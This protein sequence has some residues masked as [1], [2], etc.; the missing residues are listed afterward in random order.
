MGIDARRFKQA[1][2]VSAEDRAVGAGLGSGFSNFMTGTLASPFL[3][4]K[5]RRFSAK[6]FRVRPMQHLKRI[7]GRE[8][9][10]SGVTLAGVSVLGGALK[11]KVQAA[12]EARSKKASAAGSM[13]HSGDLLRVSAP[14]SAR[15]GA[16]DKVE[17]RRPKGTAL[18][19]FIRSRGGT[20][21][22]N[23]DM[24]A[25][26]ADL[27]RRAKA[28][29]KK[30]QASIDRREKRSSKMGIMV[31]QR[32][33]NELPETKRPPNATG[34]MARMF[35]N[36]VHPGHALHRRSQRNE[37][38]WMS[39]NGEFIEIGGRPGAIEAMQEVLGVKPDQVLTRQEVTALVAEKGQSK[40][41][42][43][44]IRRSRRK[45]KEH[46]YTHSPDDVSEILGVF[47]QLME[48]P[49]AKFFQVVG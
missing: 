19:R 20:K 43:F 28:G 23:G 42:A 25:H 41:D 12:Y 24:M 39:E 40:K 14:V 2:A 10:G 3:F 13:G 1:A 44:A 11:E 27:A 4:S 37:D 18:Q 46:A 36:K 32:D 7:Y 26:Y 31:Y 35:G 38:E 29:D 8:A 16:G 22:A 34:R 9:L 33:P 30:A 17:R 15:K 21:T 5:T 45:A 49:Q 48:N 47:G 6:K